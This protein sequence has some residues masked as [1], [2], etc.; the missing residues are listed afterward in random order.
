MSHCLKA[1]LPGR[2]GRSIR[3]VDSVIRTLPLVI[4]RC[5]VSSISYYV[6]PCYII[7]YAIN[8]YK[9]ILQCNSIVYAMLYHIIHDMLCYIKQYVYIMHYMQCLVDIAYY[10]V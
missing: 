7:V 2:P 10:A 1:I 4:R 5:P 6:M 9:V 3:V 8:M